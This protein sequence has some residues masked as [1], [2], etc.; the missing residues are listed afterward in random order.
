MQLLQIEFNACYY[1]YYKGF[2]LERE[3]RTVVKKLAILMSIFFIFDRIMYYKIKQDYTQHKLAMAADI[4]IEKKDK[5]LS[6][7]SKARQFLAA[8]VSKTRTATGRKMA[9]LAKSK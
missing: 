8:Q 6:K 1:S 9:Y 5:L 2:V 3:V 7:K 4:V